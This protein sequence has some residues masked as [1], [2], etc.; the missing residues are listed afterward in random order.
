MDGAHG[1]YDGRSEQ[2]RGKAPVHPGAYL[3]LDDHA[4]RKQE[5]QEPAHQGDQYVSKEVILSATCGA[6]IC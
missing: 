1:T 3:A 4:T 2:R 6:F 5:Y